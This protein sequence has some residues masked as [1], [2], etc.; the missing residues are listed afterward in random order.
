M[1]V[2]RDH[3]RQKQGLMDWRTYLWKGDMFIHKEKE[4]IRHLEQNKAI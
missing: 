1:A 3:K 4:F 2:I